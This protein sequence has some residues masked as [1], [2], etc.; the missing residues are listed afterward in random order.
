MNNTDVI[1]SISSV[2]DIEKITDNTKYINIAIDNYDADVIN[3]FINNGFYYSYYDSINGNNGF[4]YTNY[5]TF[6][7]GEEIIAGIINNMPN[8][9]NDLE[10]VRYLYVTIGKIISIDI[11]TLEDKNEVISFNN[12]SMVNNIWGCLSLGKCSNIS[13]CKLLMLLCSR[14]NIRCELVSNSII[15]YFF[16]Y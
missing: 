14:L 15:N 10:K 16:I 11:N 13:I 5:N 8:D 6:K 4:I 7:M 1:V 9:L 2:K 3:Y 12:I